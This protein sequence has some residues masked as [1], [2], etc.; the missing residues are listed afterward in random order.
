MTETQWN[1]A[2][3]LFREEGTLPG[4]VVDRSS[5]PQGGGGATDYQRAQGIVKELLAK[6]RFQLPE[7]KVREIDNVILKDG[8]K[9]GLEKLPV[10]PD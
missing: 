2:Q 10:F 1:R 5:A 9:F 4:K 3:K 6:D 7:D 8:S